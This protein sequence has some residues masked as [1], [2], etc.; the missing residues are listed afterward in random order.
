MGDLI[1]PLVALLLAV[2]G[3]NWGLAIFNINLVTM[4]LG[5]IPMLVTAVYALVGLAGLYKL[6][7]ILGIVK[8][9]Q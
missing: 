8:H 2:G 1:K 7:M 3:I 5:S 9:S 6:A 4:I